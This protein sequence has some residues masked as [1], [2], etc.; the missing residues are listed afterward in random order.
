MTAPCWYAGLMTGTVLDGQIDLALIRTDGREIVEFGPTGAMPYPA[1]LRDQLAACVEA[2]AA[3]NFD[4]PEP[5]ITEQIER[6]LT[7][8]STT[9]TAA[10]WVIDWVH[11]NTSN[12]RS[13]TSPSNSTSFAEFS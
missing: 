1:M 12:S 2:A 9:F 3:W 13:H 8:R 10:M 7:T 11:H 5:A 4:G 6:D